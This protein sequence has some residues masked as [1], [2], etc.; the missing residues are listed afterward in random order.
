M[1]AEERALFAA[2]LH[3]V[4]AGN[5]GAALDAALDEVGWR[6]AL[7]ADPRAATSLLFAQQGAAGATSSA[8]DLVLRDALGLDL[9]ADVGVVLPPLGRTD[10]PGSVVGEGAAVGGLALAGLSGRDRALVVA[11]AAEGCVAAIVDTGDL[12]L[13]T[14]HGLDPRLGIV[15]VSGAHAPATWRSDV[16]P[17]AWAAAVAAGQRALGHE[18]VGASRTMLGFARDHAVERVQFGRPIA[19][20]QAVRHRLAEAYVAIEAADAALTAAWDDGTPLTAAMAKAIAGRSAR[21][22]SRHCQQVLAGIGFTTEHALHLFV[23]RVIVLDRLLGDARSLTRRLG[24]DL[25]AARSL[26]AILPL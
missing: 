10:P 11:G 14:V 6:E 12:D 7:P 13:R 3:Q 1:D 19:Q 8:L 15:E 22:V 20:F 17:I 18:L 4:T 26:P 2:S 24:E 9:D 16:P 5:T 23:R 21:T 25:L